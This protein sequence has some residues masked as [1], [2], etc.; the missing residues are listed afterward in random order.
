MASPIGSYGDDR[1]I[2]VC[3]KSIPK[4]C[5]E[6][7]FGKHITHRLTIYR[8]GDLWVSDQ[9]VASVHRRYGIAPALN[10]CQKTTWKKILSAHI[11]VLA[12]GDFFTVE[13]L[14]WRGSA[15]SYILFFI[16]LETRRV[17]L[18]GITR[19]PTKEWMT[20]MARN[21]MDE[22]SGRLRQHR[23]VVPRQH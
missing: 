12:G 10:R 2:I 16:P 1:R 11:A 6:T 7:T 21:V 20:Q 5:K 13:V 9:T 3:D 23:E 15:T 19:H 22:P 8:G 18:A 4:F 17:S 14:T